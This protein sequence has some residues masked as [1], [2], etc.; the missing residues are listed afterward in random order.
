[1]PDFL[2]SGPPDA[3]TTLLLAHGA[4]SPMDSNWMNALV[5]KLGE[6]GLR[7]A[8]FE[9]AYMAQRRV[10]GRKPPPSRTEALMGEY[11]AVLEM[12]KPAGRLLIGGKSLGGRVAS[13]IADEA[14]EAG[15]IEGLVCFG[16]P[17]HP[18]G[19]P[20]KLR[21][22][23]LD[24]LRCPTLVFQGTR[25]PFGSRVEAGAY[26]LSASITLDWLEGDHGLKPRADDSVTL[27][28]NLSLAAS[29]TAA[30]S[31]V[32][33]VDHPLAIAAQKSI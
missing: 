22:A 5:L 20:E 24:T 12:L 28:E 23:H 9:F 8:R 6:A 27:D 30:W 31:K 17:F 21:T 32:G 14:F 11:R 16:Y 25:D 15:T 33:A 3:D 26:P 2:F 13:M 7:C 18:P 4:G 1:M 29:R 10:D 19:K